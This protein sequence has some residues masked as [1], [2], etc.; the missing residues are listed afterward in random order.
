MPDRVVEATAPVI[1]DLAGCGSDS[2]LQSLPSG[3]VAAVGV[4]IDRRVGCRVRIAPN[5]IVLESS[6]TGQISSGA[7]LQELEPGDALRICAEVLRAMDVMTGLR[8]STQCRIPSSSGLAVAPSIAVV[9]VA[10]VARFLGRVISNDELL[11]IARKALVR[12]STR[13]AW[14]YALLGVIG[15]AVSRV[16]CAAGRPLAG[17][18][19]VDPARVEECLFLVDTGA[20]F[21]PPTGRSDMSM[22]EATPDLLSEGHQVAGALLEGRLEDVTGILARGWSIRHDLGL[23]PNGP[24]CSRIAALAGEHGAAAR[25]VG[26]GDGGLLALWALPGSRSPGPREA[27]QAALRGAGFRVFPI[28][29]DLLGLE[30]EERS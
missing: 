6:D 9:I 12:A 20:P 30:V 25:P 16:E 13:P 26:R 23:G 18:L 1:L 19:L 11:S 8:V 28:R 27:V 17:P 7:T 21:V 2:H 5:G 10:A 29:V 24:V 4:A 3:T 22:P 15:G 14:N